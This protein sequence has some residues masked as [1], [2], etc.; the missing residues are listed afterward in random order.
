MIASLV[1]GV[2]LSAGPQH[3][4]VYTRPPKWFDP[5]FPNGNIAGGIYDPKSKFMLA[6]GSDCD[7]AI[8]YAVL[9]KDRHEVAGMGFTVPNF[10]PA[11]D[12]GSGNQKMM[13]GH[14]S[15]RT[16]K[17]VRIGDAESQL[18]A[19]LGQPH[20]IRMEGSLKQFKVYEYEWHRPGHGSPGDHRYVEGRDYTQCYTFKKGRL[21]EIRHDSYL[22]EE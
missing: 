11:T 5:E 2:V 18:V 8:R 9:T 19:K 17:G 15:L 21:I 12:S 10:E 20:K 16:R 14:L 3:H 22:E 6:G 1:L 13:I 7:G 4:R